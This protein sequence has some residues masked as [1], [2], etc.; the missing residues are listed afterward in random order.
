MLLLR[1]RNSTFLWCFFLIAPF[2]SIPFVFVEIVNRRK[3]ALCLLALFIAMCA[4]YHPPIWGDILLYRDT[5]QLFAYMDLNDV[6]EYIVTGD[7]L[8]YSLLV[9]FAKLNIPFNYIL[10]IFV[11]VSTSIYLYIY[12]DI[13]EH[14]R[15]ISRKT[16]IILLFGFIFLLISSYYYVVSGLRNGLAVSFFA[17][18]LYLF[19]IRKQK[20]IPFLFLFFSAITHFS[21]LL[22]V[23][24]WFFSQLTAIRMHI[25]LTL[26]LAI[27]ISLSVSQLLSHIDMFS[28]L[29][30]Y[31]KL[32][33]YTDEDWYLLQYPPLYRFI[34]IS[35]YFLA[36]P[37]LLIFFQERKVCGYSSFIVLLVGLLIVVWDFPT[38]Y[39]RFLRLAMT[40]VFI[41]LMVNGALLKQKNMWIIIFSAL[42]SLMSIAHINKIYYQDGGGKDYM[43]FL[44][45][46]YPLLFNHNYTD[47]WV[48]KYSR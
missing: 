19:H 32:L 28:D 35:Q 37:L 15:N 44:Y 8:L 14:G 27:L 36:Y 20:F 10:F 26:I 25:K 40:V 47:Y 31:E 30:F 6:F 17:M 43:R 4:F 22:I 38:T 2:W 39:G 18:F 34:F 29:F 9:C 5:Y 16:T 45:T 1:R 7:F 11:F 23:L 48:Q 21:M 13:I 3:Y 24:I 42:F 12:A 33:A 41:Y 46:P